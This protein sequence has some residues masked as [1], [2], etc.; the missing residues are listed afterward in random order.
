MRQNNSFLSN[1]LIGQNRL[2]EKDQF[3]QI[4]SDQKS[5]NVQNKPIDEDQNSPNY[6]YLKGLHGLN[7][8]IKMDFSVHFFLLWSEES[9]LWKKAD[10]KASKQSSNA[11]NNGL[12]GHNKVVRKYRNSQFCFHQM[13]L[14][15][16]FKPFEK[17]QNRSINAYEKG[18]TVNM[19][20][21][22]DQN[23]KNLF[24]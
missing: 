15:V 19:V 8:L 2:V 13:S 16:Q 22:W 17:G 7:S 20:D 18:L 10:W 14:N 11:Y 9:K 4:C 24:D 3:D 21:K 6:A 12:N 23:S 1:G 5:L